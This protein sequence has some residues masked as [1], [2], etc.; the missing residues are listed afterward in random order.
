MGAI[1]DIR[2]DLL[3]R[4]TVGPAPAAS[5][6]S[7]SQQLAVEQLTAA[8][9]ELDGILRE[10]E[11]LK[12]RARSSYDWRVLMMFIAGQRP[13]ITQLSSQ[14][15]RVYAKVFG[16]AYDEQ[17]GAAGEHNGGKAPSN[18][19]AEIRAKAQAGLAY[20]AADR[21]ERTGKDLQ[22]LMWA[23]K[24]VA[25][26]LDADQHAEQFDAHDERLFGAAE[27]GRAS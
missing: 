9:V 24:A 4:P 10:V 8:V 2:G 27:A 7:A 22:D 20:E 3:S 17:Y 6:P 12:K 1:E 15:K 14:A 25:D 16:D 23:C 21:L 5:A 19:T 18:K 26:S 13:R 11:E